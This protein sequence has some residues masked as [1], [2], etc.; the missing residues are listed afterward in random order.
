MFALEMFCRSIGRLALAAPIAVGILLAG[1]DAPQMNGRAFAQAAQ[2]QQ[3]DPPQVQQPGQNT[4]SADVRATLSQFG[5]FVQHPKYGEVWTPTVTPQGWHPYE[6]CHWVNSKKYGWY[7]DDKRPWGQIV[8]HYGRWTHDAQMG[9]IWV[10]G[11]EFSPG[12]VVWRS[13]PQWIGWA[14]QLPDEDL[15]TVSADDFNN[16]GFW[17]FMEVAK[18][19]QG[20]NADQIIPAQQIPVILRQTQFVTEIDYLQG[21]AIFVLPPYIIGPLIDIEIDFTPWDPAFYF[22][23]LIDLNAMFNDFNVIVDVNF[24]DCTKPDIVPAIYTPPKPPSPPPQ[25]LPPAPPPLPPAVQANCPDGSPLIAGVPCSGPS[26]PVNCPRG[27]HREA[28]FCVANII[29]A[30]PDD[31]PRDA[32]GQCRSNP[33]PYVCPNGSP[34]DRLTGSCPPVV[35]S[36]QFPMI[37]HDG[38]CTDPGRNVCP[39]GSPRDPRTGACPPVVSTCLPPKAMR[40]GVCVDQVANCPGGGRPDPRTGQ[41]SP[42]PTNCVAPKVMR[43]GVCMDQVANCPGG[44]RPD[45]R[46]GQCA[47]PPPNCAPPKV[48]V[49]GICT[50]RV[51]TQI[52]APPKT[53]SNG[54]CVDRIVVPPACLPPKAMINGQCMDRIAQPACAPPRMMRGSQCVDPIAARPVCSPPQVMRG[55]QCVSAVV[56]RGDSSPQGASPN[57]PFNPAI[58]HPSYGNGPNGNPA[59]TVTQR[60]PVLPIVQRRPPATVTPATPPRPSIVLNRGGGGQ[61]VFNQAAA[62]PARTTPQPAVHPMPTMIMPRGGPPG[63][64]GSQQIR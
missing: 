51:V 55:G 31:R 63:G 12:W 32:F 33:P 52:C 43:D 23:L 16:G 27:T 47:P 59:A 61:N 28:S 49:G 4:P 19:D 25:V 2:T 57:G 13:S 24:I 29:P 15:T 50:D 7:F 3:S 35:V 1:V 53:M 64:G 54:Q 34:P 45:L 42:L 56:P 30:C 10:P 21:I 26:R 62:G 8:H 5:T 39:N 46:T 40:D 11:A 22:Q 18:F 37:L 20:C 17:T 58:R 6:A 48:V 41:C 44:G 9:W 60:P 14:P 36:C 38:V